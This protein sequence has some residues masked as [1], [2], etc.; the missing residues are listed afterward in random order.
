METAFWEYHSGL[1]R[2]GE[3]VDPDVQGIRQFCSQ[4]Q[5]PRAVHARP[6]VEDRGDTERLAYFSEARSCQGRC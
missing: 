6:H 2:D 3:P 5:D 1:P 4:V